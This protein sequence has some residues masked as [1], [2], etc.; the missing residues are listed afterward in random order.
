M[1]LGLGGGEMACLGLGLTL[2]EPT[3][4]VRGLA[5]GEVDSNL[6]LAG[7]ELKKLDR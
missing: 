6:G 7:G 4:L 3:R 2:G 5:T 1:D